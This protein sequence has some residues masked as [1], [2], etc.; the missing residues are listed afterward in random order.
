MPRQRVWIEGHTFQ[1][2]GCS[3]CDWVFKPSGELVGKDLEE[4]KGKYEA[5]WDKEFAAHVCV[6]YPRRA[7]I[8]KTKK[9]E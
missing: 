3:K 2:F 9:S 6:E 7:A 4:M 5:Q 1:G 8:P